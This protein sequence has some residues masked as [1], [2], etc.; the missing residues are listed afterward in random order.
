[1]RTVTFFDKSVVDLVK[2]N[3]ACAWVNIRPDVR[4]P[5]NLYKRPRLGLTNATGIGNVSLIFATPDRKV[6]HVLP[7]YWDPD[8]LEHEIK[9][10][11]KLRDAVLDRNY[12]LKKDA[13]EI[14]D[15]MHQEHAKEH[16]SHKHGDYGQNVLATMHE[17]FTKET[18]QRIEQIDDNQ[19]VRM[20]SGWGG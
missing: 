19:L 11:L 9:F 16:R 7:G 2:K 3:F 14:F 13:A 20:T 8:T 10:V 6:L 17:H 18:F 15:R 5:P 12:K 4:F 1:M